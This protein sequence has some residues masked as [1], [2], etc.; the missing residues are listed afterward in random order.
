VPAGTIVSLDLTGD[1]RLPFGSG[2][3]PC[4]GRAHAL[5]LAAGTLEAVV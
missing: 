2:L 4:P 3:R 5:A 1:E